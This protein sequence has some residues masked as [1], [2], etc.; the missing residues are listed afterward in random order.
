MMSTI[1]T[2]A[3]IIT[4]PAE[5]Y[6][7]RPEISRGMLFDFHER[8]RVF[9]GR[10]ITGTIPKLK[11]SKSLDNGSLT[12]A[13]LLEPDRVN[14]MFVVI[15]DD[16]LASNGALSTKAAKEFVANA[17]ARR[18]IAIKA[19]QL[20]A[21]QA[22]RDSVIA[23]CGGWIGK[24]ALVEQTIIWQH[25]ATNIACRCKPDWIRPTKS[26]GVLAFDLK[27]TADIS[28]H[29]FRSSIEN[30]GYWLQDAHYCEGIEQATGKE[31]EAFCFVAVESEPP[32]V[33]RVFQLDPSSRALARDAREDLMQDLALRFGSGDWSD[34][35][36]GKVIPVSVRDFA[37]RRGE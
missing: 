14:S 32:Y 20:D 1:T 10:Y 18:Q 21:I 3:Q 24:A 26:G 9:E 12:H 27:T 31:V 19:E 30:Y 34:P 8:P 17:Q 4:E 28:L 23:A 11:A 5:S 15:P 22:M 7:A 6:H 37:F 35:Q 29:G 25:P 16:M 13:A 33:C 36:E 2:Q